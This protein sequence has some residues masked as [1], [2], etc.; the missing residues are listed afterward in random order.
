MAALITAH[1]ATHARGAVA[2]VEKVKRPTIS[3][4]GTSEEWAYFLTRWSDYVSATKIDGH[5]R[6]V[7][8]LECCDDPL[9]KDLTRQAGG[10]L[11]GKDIAEVLA[12]I[13]KLAVRE[14]N[15][16]VARVALHN[17]SMHLEVVES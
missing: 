15:S 13:K 6:V 10:S 2:K 11:T 8:L 9:R 14:E 3:A 1:S 5:D 7:Q 16:M 17:I 4:A 12:A